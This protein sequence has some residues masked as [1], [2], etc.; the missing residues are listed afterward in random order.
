MDTKKPRAARRRTMVKKQKGTAIFEEV[1]EVE[2]V[3]PR[4][5]ELL[6][7]EPE[8][9]RIY[10]RVRNRRTIGGIQVDSECTKGTEA[11]ERL[12]S[13]GSRSSFCFDI[14]LL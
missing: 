11:A 13:W 10:I 5:L 3:A 4:M 6:L 7:T 12:H 9:T 1:D 2:D 14:S 8:G